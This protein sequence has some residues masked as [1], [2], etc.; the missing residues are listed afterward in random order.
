MKNDEQLKDVIHGCLT[1]LDTCAELWSQEKPICASERERKF[2]EQE[3]YRPFHGA[4][5]ETAQFLLKS[6]DDIDGGKA[7]F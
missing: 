3:C 6:L 7:C 1:Y 5:L 2:M 4:P